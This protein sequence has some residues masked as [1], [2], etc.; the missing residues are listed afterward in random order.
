[1]V[2]QLLERGLGHGAPSGLE[3]LGRVVLPTVPACHAGITAGQRPRA[4]SSRS[5]A[6]T[7]C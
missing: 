2:G 6:E 1:V 3:V 7:A 4:E 5:Q